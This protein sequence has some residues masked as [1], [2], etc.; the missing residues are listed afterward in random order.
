M[1]LKIADIL[2]REKRPGLLLGNRNKQLVEA[3][4]RQWKTRGRSVAASKR[5]SLERE[6]M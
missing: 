1:R 6:R 3:R 2:S 5:K 4:G